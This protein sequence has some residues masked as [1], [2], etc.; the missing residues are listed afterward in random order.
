MLSFSWCK[1]L[2]PCPD[3]NMAIG[4]GFSKAAAVPQARGQGLLGELPTTRSA[5]SSFQK[6]H[7]VLGSMM[8]REAAKQQQCHGSVQTHSIGRLH[9][10]HL[11]EILSPSRATEV[12]KIYWRQWQGPKEG[13][14]VTNKESLN[15]RAHQV[16]NG[17]EQNTGNILAEIIVSREWIFPVFFSARGI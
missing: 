6:V 17:E 10:E 5:G 12:G 8:E 3:T 15:V 4:S 9:L 7:Q 1:P 14:G 13:N 16:V 11:M 2:D